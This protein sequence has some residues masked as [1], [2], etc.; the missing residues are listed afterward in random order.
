[1]DANVLSESK[2][3]D[4]IQRLIG[5]YEQNNRNLPWR[6]TN[7][8]Y[9]I[10]VSEVI[11]QQTRVVQGFDYYLRF[12]ERFPTV[13]I[14]AESSEKE[15]LKA[16]QGLG[17]YTRARNLHKGAKEVVELYDGILPETYKEIISIRGIG[18]YTAAAILS[19]AYNKPYAVVD[20]NV[21]RVLS[22]LFAIETPIDSSVGKKQFSKLAQQLLDVSNPGKYNQ[23]IMEFGALHCTP[24]K[25]LC[26]SCPLEHLCLSRKLNMQLDLPVKSKKVKVRSRY[27]HY[28]Q[29]EYNGFTYLNKRQENDI[30]K[31]MYE[32]PLIET[33]EDTNLTELMNSHYFSSLFGN[34]EIIIQPNQKQIKHILTHQHIYAN[35]YTIK[36]TKL[37]EGLF[38]DFVKIKVDN[39]SQYPIS[40]LI[41]R[42]LEQK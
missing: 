29:I 30:W 7:D 19:I 20:G 24:S 22:R 23:A 8:S 31:N 39:I 5:W 21:Y 16:W 4:L 28:F 32:F 34:A 15:V 38:E 26:E 35:F 27:F 11:L 1:M 37:N 17:Y 40:R 10:W 14:L 42:Y 6:E 9:K 3:R 12:I 36:A 41:H 2:R 18:V 25:P 13:K 33:V